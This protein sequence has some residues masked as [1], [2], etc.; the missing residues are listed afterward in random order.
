[1]GAT[2]AQLKQVLEE[3]LKLYSRY[4]DL[5]RQDKES[6]LRMD[7][8]GLEQSNKEKSTIMLKLQIADSSRQQY[9]RRIAVEQKNTGTKVSAEGGGELPTLEEIAKST[10][11]TERKV[12]LELRA[13]LKETIL[14]VKELTDNN[15]LV[16]NNS[17]RW[18][19]TSLN[20][21]NNFLTPGIYSQRGKVVQGVLQGNIVERSV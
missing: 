15:T 5:L 10:G 7:I 16:A 20:Y 18:M 14:Q 11:I 3:E 19:S 17:L 4:L 12:L 8:E 13:K 9:T 2:V 1:M 6:M 21:L